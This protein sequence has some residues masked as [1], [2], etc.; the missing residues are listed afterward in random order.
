MKPLIPEITKLKPR[1]VLVVTSI[2]NPNK[3]TPFL[4]ALYGTAYGTKF[5][6]FKP[7]GKKMEIGVLAARWPDA[8]LKPKN[9]WKGIW[10]LQVS[11]FVKQSD[12]IQK[13]PKKIGRAH[14]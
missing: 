7:K 10:A 3:A 13:D 11:D 6:V 12:L 8:H 9:K 2:G 5:K 14:V 1:K 4:K